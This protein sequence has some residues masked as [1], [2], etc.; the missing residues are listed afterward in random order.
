MR[1]A[2]LT[3]SNLQA[4]SV[5]VDADLAATDSTVVV[6]EPLAGHPE[7]SGETP[8]VEGLDWIVNFREATTVPIAVQGVLVAELQFS[9]DGG[10]NFLPAQ[11]V[12]VATGDPAL[13]ASGRF[14]RA[15]KIGRKFFDELGVVDPAN[16]RWKTVYSTTGRVM[17]D[18]AATV[19][20]TSYLTRG[21]AE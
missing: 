8:L 3:M 10:A 9:I 15:V 18:A 6:P 4:L 1:D 19:R 2:L 7:P 11:G 20:V 17:G 16:V 5:L 13:A 21:A 12:E 14:R